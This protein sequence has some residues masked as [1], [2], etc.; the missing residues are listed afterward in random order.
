MPGNRGDA[1]SAK[2]LG[3]GR[4]HHRPR[5]LGAVEGR[6]TIDRT[7]AQPKGLLHHHRRSRRRRAVRGRDVSLPEKVADLVIN[8]VPT[9]LIERPV[10]GGVIHVGSTVPAVGVQDHL[11]PAATRQP[12]DGVKWQAHRIGGSRGRDRD[13]ELGIAIRHELERDVFKAGP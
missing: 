3:D 4:S 2:R 9:I 10:I 6:P 8:Q 12:A 13:E 11:V 7:P 1:T 5:N